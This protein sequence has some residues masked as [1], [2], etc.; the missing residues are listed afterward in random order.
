MEVKE[1]AEVR[2][3][4][5]EELKLVIK[6]KT[7]QIFLLETQLQKIDL[8]FSSDSDT[9]AKVEE[10]PKHSRIMEKVTE[11]KRKILTVLGKENYSKF[12]E[13]MYENGG[14]DDTTMRTDLTKI[15]GSKKLGLLHLGN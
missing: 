11:M 4:D 3:Q 15:I 1:K 8:I 5:I 14:K 2:R 12:M 13:Y 10:N 7:Q 9:E 6:E